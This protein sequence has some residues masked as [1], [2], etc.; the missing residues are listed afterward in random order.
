M[1]RLRGDPI[2]T[3]E[4][5]SCLFVSILQLK[6]PTVHRMLSEKVTCA[7]F[8]PVSVHTV[9]LTS[10]ALPAIPAATFRLRGFSNGACYFIKMTMAESNPDMGP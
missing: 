7:T 6:P 1:L 3:R 4:I 2:L 5:S 8:L 9:L 10:A